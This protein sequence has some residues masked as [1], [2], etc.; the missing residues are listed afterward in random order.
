MV[1][2][3]YLWIQPLAVS[4]P[5][6]LP[7]FVERL[8]EQHAAQTECWIVPRIV[9]GAPLSG[10]GLRLRMGEASRLVVF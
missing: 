8:T 1:K 5:D 4:R 2:M 7:L 6:G 3:P 10:A 9:T